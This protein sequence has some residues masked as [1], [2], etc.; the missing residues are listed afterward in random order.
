M[1]KS[2]YQKYADAVEFSG[3]KI[4]PQFLLV[5][6][7]IG[8]FASILISFFIPFIDFTVSILAILL[9]IDIGLGLPFYLKDKKIAEI[10]SKLPDVLRHIAITIK[11][12][13]TI[14]TA[15]KEASRVDYGP[16]TPGLKK[17]LLQ[18]N[19]G[20]TFEEAFTNFA[21]ESH[22]NLLE[23]AAIIIVAARKAGGGLLETLTSMAEDFRA[24]Y[25]L[26]RERQSKTFLQFLFILVA[27]VFIAPFVF[28]I[29]K[30]V[31][32]ILVQVG[33]EPTASTDALV[34]KF[35]TLF[36]VY[37]ILQA[38][39]SSIGAFQVREGKISKAIT[40][41]P[42]AAIISYAIYIVVS[43]QFIALLSAG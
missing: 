16:I 11:T 14:E 19:E 30:S 5:L 31:L 1:S 21:L 7:L 32:Q 33:G 29:V 35:N 2:L 13:G 18:I 17:M 24:L 41:I 42:I 6:T 34:S 23:K 26:Q 3:M 4:K 28:G 22:S 40:F 10:E 12:G 38:A 25:R 20:K 27:G 8:V 9:I 43:T 15:L 37:L 36:K 39:L